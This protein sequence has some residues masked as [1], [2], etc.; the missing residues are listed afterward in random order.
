MGGLP[1]AGAAIG[2]AHRPFSS[3][4]QGWIGRVAGIRK[5]SGAIRWNAAHMLLPHGHTGRRANIFAAVEVRWCPGGPPA[6]LPLF[7]FS[8]H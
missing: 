1:A 3:I 2:K 8:A 6:P 7:Y 4:V 5:K